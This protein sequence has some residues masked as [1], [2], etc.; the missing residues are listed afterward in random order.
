M[1]TLFGS[2]NKGT[3][4]SKIIKTVPGA[5]TAGNFL[6]GFA[7]AQI[8]FSEIIGE[9]SLVILD[10]KHIILLVIGQ[11]VNHFSQFIAPENIR[12]A[13]K[14]FFLVRHQIIISSLKFGEFF[15]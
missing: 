14:D 11:S 13:P 12:D 10:K 1:R 2:R 3:N 9:R 8:A 6:L 4:E 15:V 7:W 5:E